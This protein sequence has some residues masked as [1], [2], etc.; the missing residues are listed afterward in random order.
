MDKLFS[1]LYK[2]TTKRNYMAGFPVK[3]NIIVNKI[4]NITQVIYTLIALTTIV[5]EYGFFINT[6]ILRIIY[7]L[8]KIILFG[9][10]VNAFVK[11]IFIHRNVYYYKRHIIE[12]LLCVLLLLYILLPGII[13][14]LILSINPGLTPVILTTIYLIITQA[15]IVVQGIVGL[16]GYSKRIL[17]L[18]IQPSI[19]IVVSFFSLILIGTLLLLLPKATAFPGISFVDALFVSTS[20]VCV[21]GLTVVDVSNVFTLTGHVIIM[22]LIQSGG[23]GIMTLT[24]FLLF[25]LGSRTQLKEYITIQSIISEDNLG[26]IRNTIIT[27]ISFTFIIELLGG[28]GI[29]Y[30]V[31]PSLF[32]GTGD[33]IFFSAFHS[34]SAF[35]NA[36]FTTTYNNLNNPV[37]QFNY[38]ALITIMVLISLGGLGF[39]VLLN[40]FKY[41]ISIGRKNRVKNRINLHTR[42]VLICSLV[43]VLAG[44]IFIL[45][46]EYSGSMANLTLDQKILTSLF[47]SVSA[48]TAGFNTIYL[49][50]LAVPTVFIIMILMWIGA[51]PASTGGGIKTTTISI[52]IINIIATLNGRNKSEIFKKQISDL[53]ITKAFSIIILSIFYLL[54]AM[55]VLLLSENFKFE[56]IAFELVSA[57]GTVGLSRGITP[58]LSITGK[59]VIILSM[60]IGRVGIMTFLLIMIKKKNYG[61]YS[62]TQEN[63][64]IT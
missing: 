37:L 33:Q 10:L 32:H 2:K 46:L 44:T 45:I 55:F 9:F 64:L 42:L 15:F 47:H 22:L 34:I 5:M 39:P 48:R 29:F 58:S 6:D 30:S 28:F 27:I 8:Q 59:I 40:L 17:R 57:F 7:L 19:I 13:S 62:Y 52:A 49:E 31:D 56:D 18:N 60:F 41:I 51:S 25:F 3:M 21:T 12:M 36:G 4:I 1:N 50:Q 20:A 61:N 38:G 43:L 16:I 24:T 35:C 26:K 53:S 54:I 14:S 63:I 11:F 23:L